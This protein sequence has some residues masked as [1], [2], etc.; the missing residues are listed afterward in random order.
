MRKPPKR[1]TSWRTCP[2]CGDRSTKIFCLNDGE[3]RCQICD[4][5]YTFA[6]RHKPA[7]GTW[8]AIRHIGMGA[9]LPA[10]RN[11]FGAAST[12]ME[13]TTT[14]PPRLFKT[15]KAARNALRCWLQGRWSQ[16]VERGSTPDTYLEV[17]VYHEAEPDPRR[18]AAANDIAVVAVTLHVAGH[19]AVVEP[20]PEDEVCVS[21]PGLEAEEE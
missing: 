13:F 14:Q 9:Y 6:P 5:T 1:V 18:T 8:Y 12:R 10:K 11:K 4:H 16:V 2:A 19:T 21:F 15:E 7:P 17:D 20:Q 3:Y